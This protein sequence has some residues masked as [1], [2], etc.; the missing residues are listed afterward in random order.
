MSK[1]FCT[2]RFVYFCD[3]I[4]FEEQNFEDCKFYTF[5]EK[6]PNSCSN[7]VGRLCFNRKANLHAKDGEMCDK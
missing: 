2:R 7:K 6:N 3:A 4:T 1:N 5:S